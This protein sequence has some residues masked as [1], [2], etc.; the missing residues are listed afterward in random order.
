MTMH[1][2]DR[3]PQSKHARERFQLK[4]TI[5]TISSED[6]YIPVA[7]HAIESCRRDLE[8][9]I[10]R[11][12][13][14]AST[15]DDYH[16]QKNAPEIAV[17][18]ADASSTVGIGPMSAVAGT[19]AA[20]A[21]EAMVDAG[22]TYAIVDNGGDIA[23][24]ND[25]TVIVGIYSGRT[26]DVSIGLEIEPRESILGICTSS[27]RI[28][29]SISF[30]NADAATIL[31]DD[32]SLADAAATAVGN[33]A[34]DIASIKDAFSI[35]KGVKPITGGLVILDGHVGMCGRVPVVEAPQRVEYITGALG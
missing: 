28:G 11:N 7:K 3:N 19:I 33:A 23:L 8:R 6:Q 2:T 9:F 14:F 30:G 16:C 21:V 5:V 4:E 18:M 27:G 12:P 24:V 22:S 32:V 13:F 35:L 34:I 31:S 1:K 17:R 20:I 25:E 10:R 15:L 29:H 26:D